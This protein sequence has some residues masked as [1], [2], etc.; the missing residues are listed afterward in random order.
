MYENVVEKRCFWTRS[1]VAGYTNRMF[2]RGKFRIDDTFLGGMG[3]VGII[4]LELFF[5]GNL[6][7]CWKMLK[8]ISSTKI[9]QIIPIPLNETGQVVLVGKDWNFSPMTWRS[10][11]AAVHTMGLVLRHPLENMSQLKDFPRM[12]KKMNN[13]W[14]H[15]LAP[16]LVF[17]T[18][19]PASR[20]GFWSVSLKPLKAEPQ[21]LLE[22]VFK[23]AI[24]KTKD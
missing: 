10:N 24:W 18:S 3:W 2:W 8:D 9:K 1:C 13:D 19:H 15:H 23:Q 6:A 20:W 14:N 12:G 5:S 7:F 21:E 17:Q 22:K 4:T 16:P 11:V